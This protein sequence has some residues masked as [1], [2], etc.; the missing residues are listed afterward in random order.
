MQTLWQDLRYGLRM[1]SKNPV[2][3]AVAVLTLALGIGV[4]TA[5]FS[6]VNGVLLQPL[7]YPHSEELV[8][9]ARTAP[10][11]D[12]PVPVS[13]PNFLDWR[14]LATQFR[15][16]AGFDGR[17][18]TIMLG[19]EPEHVLGAAISYNFLSVLQVTPTLGR[20]F[21]LQEEH[22]GNDHVALVTDAFWKQRLGASP[23]VIDRTFILNGQSFT[24][25]G[26]LP[27]GFRYVLMP[28][29][30]IFIPLNL[31]QTS[32]GTNFMSVIGRIKPRC[33]RR[34]AKWI[35]SRERWRRNI[36][37]TTRSRARW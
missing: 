29:A 30:Q 20:D 22:A 7:P 35:P 3:T 31:D 21:L 6:I 23:D 8:M 28:R 24:I 36:P 11:F 4:N 16:L 32:R 15:G 27:A 14:K 37:R 10:A 13:G 12:H 9:V 19:N 1:L 2:F 26:V 18:F 33:V 17:G 34:K 5:I 25:V